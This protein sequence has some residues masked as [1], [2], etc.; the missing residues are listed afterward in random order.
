[1]QPNSDEGGRVKICD[2]NSFKLGRWWVVSGMLHLCAP[3]V[4]L[5]MSLKGKY[6]QNKEV[7]TK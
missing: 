7:R 4:F 1:M 3:I 5:G 6:W 2:I